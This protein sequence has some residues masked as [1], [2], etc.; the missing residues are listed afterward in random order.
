M[1]APNVLLRQW[2]AKI[3]SFRL[4]PLDLC[5]K[6]GRVIA[7]LGCNGAGKST[8]LHSM[9]GLLKHVRGQCHIFGEPRHV[10]REDVMWKQQLGFV[11][12]DPILFEDLSLDVNVDAFRPHYPTWDVDYFGSMMIHAALS[13]TSLKAADLSKGQRMAFAMSMALCYRPRLLLLDEPTA[14]LDPL[15]RDFFLDQIMEAARGEQEATVFI[16][17][18]ILSDVA[19]IADEVCFIDQG[20]M[21]RHAT[22]EELIKG[23]FRVTLNPQGSLPTEF[24]GV[25]DMQRVGPLVQVVTHSW[26]ALQACL[27]EHDIEVVEIIPLGL[28]EVAL[29]RMRR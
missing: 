5:L 4:G 8:L 13:D 12:D 20:R 22:R 29:Y 26:E 24:P 6:P 10:N 18:H 2:Q 21:R 25:V 14:G 27:Q 11:M 28:D 17:T 7:L 1:N 15:I 19:R 9:V 16:S 23:W 3:G